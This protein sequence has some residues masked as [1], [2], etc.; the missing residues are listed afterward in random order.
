MRAT[1][2]VKWL[3]LTLGLLFHCVLSDNV[4]TDTPSASAMPQNAAGTTGGDIMAGV[5][6]SNQVST[7]DPAGGATGAPV[8]L[9]VQTQDTKLGQTTHPVSLDIKPT[10]RSVV[11]AT[12]KPAPTLMTTHQPLT[13]PT[14]KM[15][16]SVTTGIPQVVLMSTIP[17][18]ATNPATAPPSGGHAAGSSVSVSPTQ[19][20]ITQKPGPPPTIGTEAPTAPPTTPKMVRTTTPPKISIAPTTLGQPTVPSTS[21]PKGT[22]GGDQFFSTKENVKTTTVLL[23][24]P[25]VVTLKATEPPKSTGPTNGPTIGPTNGPTS[26]PS[27]IGKATPT[28]AQISGAAPTTLSPALTANIIAVATATKTISTA[29]GIEPE[30]FSYSLNDGEEREEQK[31]LVTV[32]RRLMVDMH[33][34]NCTVIWRRHNG[35]VLLS[36]VEVNGKVKSVIANQIYEEITKKS[37]DNKTLIAILA[38]C[39]ALLIMIVIL[40]VCASQHRKPYNENQQHLT[41]ELHT[42]ENGYHDNP[43]LE[44]MEVN[45]EMQEKKVALNGEFNDSWIV[46]MDNLLKE[47][48]PDE[49]DTHL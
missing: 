38:S 32:C 45:P 11:P 36:D 43:T 39:G 24:R 26:G 27:V 49:E 10:D 3:L 37:G 19:P 2:D 40:A 47:D 25:D 30:I 22:T 5:A 18:K 17:P 23:L 42:V 28:T 8:T 20:V 46:P 12:T 7:G 9:G 29:T 41:E 33:T 31:D 34:G 6:V 4:G 13:T 48:I 14:S 44:V 15:Q 35:K 21:A 16:N 1:V